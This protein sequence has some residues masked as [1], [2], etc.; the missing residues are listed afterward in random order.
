MRG[1]TWLI[2]AALAAAAAAPATALATPIDLGV[3]SLPSLLV[4]PAGSAHVVFAA[5]GGETYC[6]LPRGAGACDVET[7]LPLPDA[8]GVAKILRRPS[9]GALFIVQAADGERALTWLRASFDDGAS[10]QGPTAIA[11]GARHLDDALLTAD[12]QS[13][14]TI[15]DDAGA[16]D[17]QDAPLAGPAPTAALDLE[18]RPDGGAFA[19]NDGGSAVQL[20]DGRI[21]AAVDG[22]LA[23]RWRLFEGGDVYDE[24][25]WQPFGAATIR[26]AGSPALTSG[27]RGTFLLSQRQVPAQRGRRTSRAPFALRSFDAA[28]R[29][30]RAARDAGADRTVFGG[31]A[32]SQDAGGRLQLAWT[33]D[34]GHVACVVYARTGPRASS[35]FGRSTTLFRTS[36]R[37][38]RPITPAVAAAPDGRGFAVWASAGTTTTPANGHVYATPL[39]QA[40]G[41]YRP[42][43]NAYR[44][45]YC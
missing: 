2:A 6:R 1:R 10:W 23:T 7:P 33:S 21:L 41:R 4:D 30:W 9:D 36:R 38:A 27:G 37:G 14:V 39:R 26:G 35:W 18:R 29:R 32:L 40:P 15:A 44:R 20:P 17:V 43:A 28:R 13:I 22:V 34:S 16:V 25:A 42:I 5:P 31:A 3:G 8:Q 24:N 19:P 11:A 45:P 12:G